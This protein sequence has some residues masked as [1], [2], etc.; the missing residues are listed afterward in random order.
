M[1]ARLCYRDWPDRQASRGAP[2][3]PAIEAL[4]GSHARLDG[5]WVLAFTSANY[6]GLGRHPG[7][8]RALAGA[9]AR[10]GISLGMPRLLAV[11]SLSPRLEAAIARLVGQEQT[12]LFPSTSHA[13][14]DTLRL[15][16]GRSGVL[17][18]DEQAYPI[19]RDAAHAVAGRS[20]VHLFQHNR[21]A[22]LAR[23]L[24]GHAGE[25]GSK[26]V[27]CD[28]VYL[29][30][31][32][33]AALREIGP[34]ARR[35]KATVFVDDAHGLGI[36]GARPS[37]EMPYGHGGAGT[38]AHLRVAPGCLLHAGS[39][40]KAFG[41]PVAFVAGPSDV[42]DALRVGAPSHM[43]SSPPAIPL[44]AAGLAALRVNAQDGDSL[45][46]TLAARV[47]R[48]RAG[49]V[50]A[51]ICPVTRGLFPVQTL[52]FATPCL[53][54][55]T[56]RA[57]LRRGVWAALALRPPECPSGGSLRFALTVHHTEEDVDEAVAALSAIVGEA[58][59]ADLPHGE[60]AAANGPG[61]GI[62]PRRRTSRKMA[63]RL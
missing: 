7:V 51:G 30:D 10:W 2:A 23:L 37:D 29:S 49:L 21:P 54:E 48:F 17:Y 1:S 53:A 52:C 8:V 36:L 15:L 16:A 55:R 43:H 31:G 34:L 47:W 9:A 59:L 18:V 33:P 22:S 27:V 28:G 32:C 6:L 57:L 46:R 26:V 12:L 60:R 38:P 41:V 11:E 56:A 62:W 5:R 58:M 50:R 4:S 45:R 24:E 42:V 39:L 19:S 44:L 61:G 40:S 20:R 25:P 35:H 14:L 63:C 13:A 3:I